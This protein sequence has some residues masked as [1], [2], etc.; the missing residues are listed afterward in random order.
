MFIRQLEED[1]LLL[2]APNRVEYEPL[3]TRRR[4]WPCVR[5]KV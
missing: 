1:L 2:A 5:R 3:T 4:G